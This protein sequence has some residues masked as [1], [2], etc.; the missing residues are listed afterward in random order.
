MFEKTKIWGENSLQYRQVA[1][2]LE[3]AGVRWC[4]GNTPTSKIDEYKAPILLFVDRDKE[5]SYSQ[6]KDDI[7]TAHTEYDFYY[8]K[9]FISK[10][11]ES[12]AVVY[13][14]VVDT[15]CIGKKILK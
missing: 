12:K 5:L 9:R 1:E 13:C 8:A 15:P 2:I 11:G 3:N 10:Y 7:S 14:Q 4:S 6:S